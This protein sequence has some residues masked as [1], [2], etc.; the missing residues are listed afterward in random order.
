MCPIIVETLSEE[1]EESYPQDVSES[2]SI[3]ANLFGGTPS[4][5]Q[6]YSPA[7]GGPFSALTPSMWPQDLLA[8][9]AQVTFLS[10]IDKCILT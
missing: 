10:P 3:R 6:G 1:E 5:G 4:C 2:I 7:P 8:T 9:L